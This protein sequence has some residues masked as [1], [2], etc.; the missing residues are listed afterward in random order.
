MCGLLGVISYKKISPDKWLSACSAQYHRGP[1]DSGEWEGRI[2]EWNIAVAHQRLSIL[3]LSPA[4]AQPMIHPVTGSVLVYNG[5]IYNFV[6]LKAELEAAGINF[7]GH[8]DTEVLLRGLEHWGIDATLAKLNGMWAFAWIDRAKRKVHL[9]R[10]RCGEKP[11]YIAVQRDRVLFASEMKAIFRLTG[12]RRALNVQAIAEFMKLG[13]LDADRHTMFLGIE[14][15]PASGLLTLSLDGFNIVTH[16]YNYWQ[17]PVTNNAVEPFPQFVDRVRETFLDSVKIRLRSDVPVGILLSG[18]LDSSSI[19]GAAHALGAKNM[20]LL[21]L[22]SDDPSVDESPFIDAVGRHVGWPVTKI[23]LPSDPQTLFGHLKELTWNMEAPLGSLSNV[24]HYLLMRAARDNG[25]TVVLSGQGGDEIFC[26][27]RKYIGFHLQ[28]LVRQNHP[29]TAL[30]TLGSFLRN[31]TMVNQFRFAEAKRYL[32]S[33][34]STNRRS[35]LGARL[36]MCEVPAVGLLPGESLGARQRRDLLQLSVPT[37]NHFEDRT[38]MAW[39]REIRLPFLDHRLIEMLVPAPAEYKIAKGWSKFVLRSAVVDLIPPEITWRKDKQGF[40][41][42]EELWLKDALKQTILRDFF[43]PEA[44]IF[45]LGLL[46]RVAL[47]DQYERFCAQKLNGG[48]VW[49]KDIFQAI[50]LEMWLECFSEFIEDA[51]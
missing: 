32:P 23:K 48:D 25:I 30:R 3:D 17:C 34:L 46:D 8:S 41:C 1:D 12:G 16:E 21:S 22:V 47:L 50:A 15:V 36:S 40:S 42:S 5:E 29:F 44:R 49:S 10:D 19:T 13:I 37:L 6:E 28:T 27:Y 4:G 45:R 35:N 51:G 2:G 39:S 9:S 14:Q 38:S 26:G 33:K 24:A 31:G 11:L 18:G 20:T 7:V 43:H